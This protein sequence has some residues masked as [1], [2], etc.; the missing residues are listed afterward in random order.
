MQIF[1]KKINC[2]ALSLLALMLCLPLGHAQR[3]DNRQAT[4]AKRPQ[5]AIAD[6]AVKSLPP[7]ARETLALIEKG[8][9]YPYDRD[10]I[11]FSNFEKRLPAKDRGYYQEFTV[12]TPGVNHRGARRIVTG[13]SGEKYFSDDHYNT[14][15]R[16]VP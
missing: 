11:V 4:T 6:I 2:L 14:F 8:G 15:K 5:L 7:E 1:L 10:G 3:E 13:K 12:R 16:I 9:P